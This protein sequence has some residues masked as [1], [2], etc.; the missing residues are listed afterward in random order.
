ML[1]GLLQRGTKGKVMASLEKLKGRLATIKELHM[2]VST[3]KTLSAVN[4]RQYEA[5]AQALAEYAQT[6]GLGLQV[7]VRDHLLDL[8]AQEPPAKQS[9]AI[10]F[11][12]DT[13][14]CGRFNEAIVSFALQELTKAGLE[15]STLPLI[16]VGNRVALELDMRELNPEITLHLPSSLQ[17]LTTTAQTILSTLEDW[18]IKKGRQRLLLFYNRPNGHASFKTR[19]LQIYPLNLSWL[20]HLAQKPWPSRSLPIYTLP[21]QELFAALVREYYFVSLYRTLAE[22]LAS[23]HAARLEAMQAAE[24]NIE[25]GL[26]KL[27]LELNQIRQESITEELQDIVVGAQLL[28]AN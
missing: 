6:V 17:S 12:S 25:D 7:V 24:K 26:A 1:K 19:K 21:W 13:G 15:P 5:A 2:V 3:M 11:G 28:T 27:T 8:H 14:L 4:I 20:Q 16:A 18:E 23:E 10:I 22:S 9:A